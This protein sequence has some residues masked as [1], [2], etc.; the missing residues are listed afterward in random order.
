MKKLIIAALAAGLIGA[1]A[2]AQTNQVLS[3]NAVGYVKVTAASNSMVLIRNDFNDL[4]SGGAPAVSNIIGDQVPVNS[5]VFIWSRSSQS[6]NSGTR[7][8]R[9]GWGSFGSNMLNRGEGFFL[10]IPSGAGI[11]NY[12]VYLMGEV[13]DKTTAPTTTVANVTGLGLFGNPYP[14]STPLTN[15]AIVA[16][17]ANNDVVYLWNVTNQSYVSYTRSSRSG[18]GGATNVT[19]SPGEGF[20]LR[21]SITQQWSTVKPYTWP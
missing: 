8:S 16:N 5:T 1:S 4:T 2:Q 21:S 13:P 14:V 9:S 19:L 6:Y 7:S 10:K 3:R 12:T 18:W 15:I 17:A 20:W 11:S